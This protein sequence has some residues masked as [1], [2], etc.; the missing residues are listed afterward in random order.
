VP[1]DA[2]FQK[3]WPG[4]RYGLGLM[5]VPNSCGGAWSHGGDI[6]GFLPRNGVSPDGSRS[7]I[8]SVNTD[9]PM[10]K[11][12]VTMPSQDL[13]TDLIDDALRGAR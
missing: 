11:A 4:S 9:S 6:Q 10:P 3:A 13:A 2:H 7:V 8:V 5:R 12:G 1:T